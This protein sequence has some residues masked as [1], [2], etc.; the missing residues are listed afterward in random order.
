[1][2][3]QKEPPGNFHIIS[4]D[5]AH[6]VPVI[7]ANNPPRPMPSLREDSESSEHI[8]DAIAECFSSPMSSD[9]TEEGDLE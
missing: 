4:P 3:T 8:D 1:M 5:E 6:Y 9:S 7:L 2:T